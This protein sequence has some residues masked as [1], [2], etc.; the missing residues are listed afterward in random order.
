MKKLKPNVHMNN[1]K[2][3]SKL[4][5]SAKW[6][7][8]HIM[9]IRAISS[10]LIIANVTQS[11]TLF[12]SRAFRSS[13]EVGIKANNDELHENE[14]LVAIQN[15][16]DSLYLNFS[17]TSCDDETDSDGRQYW[18]RMLGNF[19]NVLTDAMNQSFRNITRIK[20]ELS[21]YLL[22]ELRMSDENEEEGLSEVDGINFALSNNNS[23]VRTKYSEVMAM[24]W[25]FILLNPRDLFNKRDS[26][27][28]TNREL[29][30]RR[31]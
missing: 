25:Y 13:K 14:L 16:I 24:P 17:Q 28:M 5:K 8:S 26:T 18:S 21:S 10:L 9:V 3:E 23:E 29:L 19:T 12:G 2:K 15:E 7:H 22:E 6:H 4:F 31:Q 30:L 27:L 20:S 11:Q 1:M